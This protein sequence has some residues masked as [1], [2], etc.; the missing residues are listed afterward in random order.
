MSELNRLLELTEQITPTAFDDLVDV[1]R[2]RSQRVHA[3]TAVGLAAAGVVAI[4]GAFSL[5]EGGS[6]TDPAPTPTPTP[7]ELFVIPEGQ[8]TT[9]VEIRSGDVHEWN[10]LATVTNAQPGHRGAADLSTTVT[11]NTEGGGG[12]WSVSPFCRTEDKDIWM[13]SRMSGG[14]GGYGPCDSEG[15]MKFRPSDIG[16]WSDSGSPEPLTVRIYLTRVTP[17]LENCLDGGDMTECFARYGRPLATTDAEFGFRVYEHPRSRFVLTLWDWYTFEAV[18]TIDLKPWIVDHAVIAAPG[19]DRLAVALPD[20]DRERLV[21]VYSL[22]GPHWDTCVEA[23]EAE[24]PNPESGS[25][26]RNAVEKTCGVHFRLLVDGEYVKPPELQ[27]TDD[28]GPSGFGYPVMY[29]D[30]GAHHVTVEVTGSDPRNVRFAIV[31][32]KEYVQ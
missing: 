1:R 24:L 6:R 7:S 8:T 12:Q 22:H 27:L 15:P 31:I 3:A 2:R 23:H 29:V 28:D 26:W 18:S 13:V 10:V 32:R 11:V 16:Q 5:S 21:G 19:S 4:L 25:D 14:A 17:E 9:P 30:P 20:S